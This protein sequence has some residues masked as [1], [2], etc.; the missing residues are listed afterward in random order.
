MNSRAKELFPMCPLRA[1]MKMNSNRFWEFFYRNGGKLK[2]Q[3]TKPRLTE[4]H[5]KNRLIFANKWNDLLQDSTDLYYCFLDEKWFY[6]TSCRKKE[7]HLPRASFETVSDAHVEPK[8]VRSRR[9]PCKIM[10]MG[11]V[12]PPIKDK[13]NG[14]ILMKRVAETCSSKSQSYHQNFSP[15][16]GLNNRLKLR[17]WRQLVPKDSY[18]TVNELLELIKQKYEIEPHV[19]KDLTFI[20]K[21]HSLS[22]RVQNLQCRKYRIDRGNEFFLKI[23]LQLNSHQKGTK[24]HYLQ[25]H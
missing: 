18:I 1:N 19:A 23:P 17:Q 8:K 15:Y 14:K 9:H 5:I 12:A 22:P 6:T 11:I 3:Q 2:R 21:S 4:E 13:F 10:Y 25:E 20:Y 16:Y 24:R 7:K